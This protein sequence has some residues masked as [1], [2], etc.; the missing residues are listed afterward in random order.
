M[1]IKKEGATMTCQQCD[2]DLICRLK[3]YGGNYEPSLQWQN[4]DGSA[5][6]KTKDGKNFVCNVPEDDESEQTKITTK[7]AT[8]P[9]DI[10]P[11][12]ITKVDFI[13]LAHLEEKLDTLLA[14]VDRIREMVTPMFQKMVDEQIGRKAE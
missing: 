1:V 6:Y 4:F 13:L 7:A 2:T 10:P 14:D 9:G 11:G 12:I 8:T 5:H 3:D